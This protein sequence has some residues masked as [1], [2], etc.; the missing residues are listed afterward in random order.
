MTV[1]FGEAGV[2]RLEAIREGVAQ[3][4]SFGVFA[5]GPANSAI[6]AEGLRLLCA[7]LGIPDPVEKEKNDE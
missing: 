6:V 3:L 5:P 1:S 4:S 2:K 7:E